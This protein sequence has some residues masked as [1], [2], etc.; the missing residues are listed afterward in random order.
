MTSSIGVPPEEAPGEY[1]LDLHRKKVQA[2]ASSYGRAELSK[3]LLIIGKE[4]DDAMM[5]RL[6]KENKTFVSVQDAYA[7][8]GAPGDCTDEGLV[9]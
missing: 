3:A 1:I 2:A 5:V 6:A 9:M 7:A 8:F 4:R